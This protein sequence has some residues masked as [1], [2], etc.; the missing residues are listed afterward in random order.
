MCAALAEKPG[1]CLSTVA[2][3]FH[4]AAF[5]CAQESSQELAN[6]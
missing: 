3:R 6:V 1:R 4:W 2:E 5:I